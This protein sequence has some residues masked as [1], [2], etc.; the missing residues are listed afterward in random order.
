MTRYFKMAFVLFLSGHFDKV[1]GHGR[2]LDPPAR[3]SMWRK[4]FDSPKNHN[5]NQMFCGGFSRQWEINN[6]KCGVCGDP[7]DGSHSHEPGG[8]FYSG[9]I[10]QTYTSGQEITID[11][12]VTANHLG[13]FEFRLC[14]NNVPDAEIT[15]DCLDQYVLP[16]KYHDGTDTGTRRPIDSSIGHFITRARLPVGVTCSHCMLQWK[17][18]TGISWGRE[19]DGHSCIGCGPQEEF[20][21]CSNIAITGSGVQI[22]TTR[23]PIT[24]SPLLTLTVTRRTSET[25]TIPTSLPQT[26]TVVT[27]QRSASR[28]YGVNLWSGGHKTL[29]DWCVYN[30]LQ[31]N[32]CPQTM[33]KCDIP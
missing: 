18:K 32:Y 14:P 23:R 28:C 33:C 25:T 16:L 17:W 26:R 21:G 27:T 30:C 1:G 12:E 31:T 6:G 10:S 9:Q 29:D 15:Q 20:Y 8:I 5:D 22:P 24:S 4:G 11:V 3:G 7:W 19:P 2:L 13:W